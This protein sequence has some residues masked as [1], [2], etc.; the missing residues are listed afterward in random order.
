MTPQVSV[1]MPVKNG[2]AY[3]QTAVSSIL[4]Q[5]IHDLELLLIDDHS[6]DGAI[7]AL[8][9]DDL[10]I[11][12]I[13]SKGHG[14]VDACNTGF[15]RSRGVYI[16]R[17]DADDIALETRL[18]EQL[19]YLQQ[20]PDV[21]IAGACVEIFSETGLQGG[22]ER[23]QHW[24]NS[25][26]SPKQVHQQIFIESPLPNPTLV[27]RRNVLQQ[28]GG[29][30]KRDWPEDYE[31]LLRADASGIAMG[32]PDGIL[33]RWREHPARLTHTDELYQRARF[34]QAKIHFLVQHR[35][36]GRP[37][38]IWGAGPTGRQVFDLLKQEGAE[39]I[40]FI[41]VH[42]RRIGGHKRGLPVWPMERIEALQNEMLLVAVG[43]PRAR[44]DIA[45][46]CSQHGKVEGR[47]YLFVA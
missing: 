5:S 27:F 35:L 15:A 24:L 7:A 26:R 20:N 16:A 42:P 30:R 1:V 43:V 19:E 9:H 37:V 22:L 45:V 13:E 8:D 29:Y 25:V 6:S 18:E 36:R 21:G 4:H 31:L 28:L 40:G 44:A 47:D 33:L 12:L 34:M 3:L 14:I 46:F 17:M 2:G 39:V 10:R 32:K 23:Y 38:V 41:E 11:E